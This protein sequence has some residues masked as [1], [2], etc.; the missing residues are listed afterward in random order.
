MAR[1]IDR[2]SYRPD[3]EQFDKLLPTRMKKF[4]LELAK[5]K[6][7]KLQF[8]RFRKEDSESFEFF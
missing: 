6:T 5:E 7:R 8:N 3:A 1:S 2:E 4:N